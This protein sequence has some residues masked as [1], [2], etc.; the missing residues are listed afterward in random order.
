[1][2][3]IQESLPYARD[4]GQNSRNIL[5]IFL[6]LIEALPNSRCASQKQHLASDCALIGAHC[7]RQ[8]DMLLLNHPQ[9]SQICALRLQ[10]ILPGYFQKGN[11]ALRQ[12]CSLTAQ[13]RHY[14]S[15]PGTV[16]TG[17]QE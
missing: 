15:P 5:L 13:E 1:H 16:C 6:L 11:S 4:V 9:K 7:F 2:G 12:N 10:Y 3:Q 8:Q 17:R 14:T